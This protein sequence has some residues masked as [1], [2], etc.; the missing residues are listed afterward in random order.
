M[1]HGTAFGKKS[2]FGICYNLFAKDNVLKLHPGTQGWRIVNDEYMIMLSEF[3]LSM[4]V[5]FEYLQ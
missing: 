1:N 3:A 4:L 5:H 2:K